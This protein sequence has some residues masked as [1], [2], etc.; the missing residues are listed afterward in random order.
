V[1][2]INFSP[3]GLIWAYVLRSY[4]KFEARVLE[5]LRLLRRRRAAALATLRFR[6][7]GIRCC[8]SGRGSA[9]FCPCLPRWASA[10]YGHE[11]PGAA[12]R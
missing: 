5:R 10:V 11:S 2:V 7:T 12:P 9:D 4:P 3:L 1:F 8:A 6:P